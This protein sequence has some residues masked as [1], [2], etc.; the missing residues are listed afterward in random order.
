MAIKPASTH[1]DPNHKLDSESNN[2]ISN[3]NSFHS[4][5]GKLIYL[6]HMH[7]EISYVV[8]KLSQFLSKLTAIHQYNV[9][10]ILH[11][12]KTEPTKRLLFK[13]SSF[14]NLIGFVD[15]YWS[16]GTKHAYLQLDIVFT[17]AH[18]SYGGRARNNTS[19]L[20]PPHM[21]NLV[22]FPMLHLNSNGFYIFYLIL[23]FYTNNLLISFVTISLQ[24]ISLII[25]CFMNVSNISK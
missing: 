10:K 15:S 4:L 3:P 16:H 20:N 11:Y 13:T 21:L 5:I 23:Q 2:F 6:T 14:S 22:L 25:W 12:I 19:F 24:S 1:M 18:H 17:L 9:L 7:P 8:Y